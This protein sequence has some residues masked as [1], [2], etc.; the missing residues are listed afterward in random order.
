MTVD[1]VLEARIESVE[2]KLSQQLEEIS[3]R[4]G[5]LEK[6]GEEK[7]SKDLREAYTAGAHSQRLAQVE[8]RVNRANLWLMGVG[9]TVAAQL[10]LRLLK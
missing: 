2:A 1:P 9:G 10:A 5:N 6:M 7:V 3:R 8:E 4:L